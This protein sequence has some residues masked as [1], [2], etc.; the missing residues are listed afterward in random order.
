MPKRNCIFHVPNSRTALKVFIKDATVVG[1]ITRTD[2]SQLLVQVLHVLIGQDISSFN[3]LSCLV[4]RSVKTNCLMPF[5]VE[6]QDKSSLHITMWITS[7]WSM[8]L[9]QSIQAMYCSHIHVSINPRSCTRRTESS[10]AVQR[11]PRKSQ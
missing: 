2:S 3:S 7:F 6:S 10:A 9:L 5:T 4:C 8:T 11:K 1:K